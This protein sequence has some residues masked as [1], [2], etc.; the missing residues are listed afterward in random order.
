MIYLF[1][2]MSE[3][4]SQSSFFFFFFS[5]TEKTLLS[6]AASASGPVANGVQSD[7]HQN[8]VSANG[9]F[10]P[11]MQL[12]SSA[13]PAAP[14]SGLVTGGEPFLMKTGP[15][16]PQHVAGTQIHGDGEKNIA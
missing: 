1:I 8:G 3:F 9:E 16:K 6:P 4:V 7:G 2:L 13:N 12:N 10:D 14:Q 11:I 5:V 15:M